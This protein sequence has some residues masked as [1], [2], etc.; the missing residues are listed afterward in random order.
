M[1]KNT[2]KSQ[3]NIK[4]RKKTIP[5]VREEGQGRHKTLSISDKSVSEGLSFSGFMSEWGSIS[6]PS[7]PLPVLSPSHLSE[8]HAL[9]SPL[10]CPLEHAPPSVSLAI[11]PFLSHLPLSFSHNAF[12]WGI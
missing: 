9:P 11:W 1:I 7:L 5:S 8:R 12:K 3:F 10:C 6:G 4:E 2:K